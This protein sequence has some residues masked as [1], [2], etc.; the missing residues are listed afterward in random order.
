MAEK[1]SIQLVSAG[2]C[3]S[4]PNNYKISRTQ[5]VSKLVDVIRKKLTIPISHSIFLFYK[6]F[7]IYP[8]MTIGDIVDHTPDATSIDIYY[9]LSQPYG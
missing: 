6:E 8:D 1:I 4:F 3:P 7:A 5:S 2:D 9:S